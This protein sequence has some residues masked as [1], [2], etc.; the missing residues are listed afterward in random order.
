M[1]TKSIAKEVKFILVNTYTKSVFK[2][3]STGYCVVVTWAGGPTV[4]E[5]GQS[6]KHLGDVKL[7]RA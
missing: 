4:Y 3:T 7:H 6:V 1:N 5:V 2:V